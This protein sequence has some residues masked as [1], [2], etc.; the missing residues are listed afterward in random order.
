[1]RCTIWDSLGV[2]SLIGAELNYAT[3]T[4]INQVKTKAFGADGKLQFRGYNKSQKLNTKSRFDGR[5]EGKVIN[6]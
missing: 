4:E 6:Y 1:M 2:E 5:H 3:L